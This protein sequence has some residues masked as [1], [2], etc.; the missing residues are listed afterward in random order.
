MKFTEE[1]ASGGGSDKYLK[2]ADGQSVYCI[3]RGDINTSYKKWNGTTYEESSKGT[4]GAGLRF[5]VNAV[6]FEDKKPVVKILEGAGHLY[7]DLKSINDEYP[8]EKTMVKIS[9]AGTGKG[10]RYS[11]MVAGPKM[12]P[13][14]KVLKS[15]DNL[16]LHSFDKNATTDDIPNF[17]EEEVPF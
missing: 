9:R 2:I 13:D 5:K 11:V 15:L 4:E 1:P 17:D 16:M 8:L 14:E 6:V 7:F 12:Q 3:F 10:T